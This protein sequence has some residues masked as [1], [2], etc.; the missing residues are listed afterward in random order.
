LKHLPLAA[1]KV[2][3]KAIVSK[4]VKRQMRRLAQ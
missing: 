4:A 1:M 2:Q 3:R